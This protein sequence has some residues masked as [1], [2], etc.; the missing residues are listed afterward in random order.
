M[1]TADL[2]RAFFAH[3]RRALTAEHERLDGLIWFVADTIS[4]LDE[5]DD[6]A[7][8]AGRARPA[9]AAPPADPE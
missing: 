5:I 6:A 9:C 2:R 7:I 4:V 3:D 1:E 8:A